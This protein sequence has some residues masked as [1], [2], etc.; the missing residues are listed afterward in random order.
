MQRQ[1]DRSLVLETVEVPI[2]AIAGTA[3]EEDYL[4]ELELIIDGELKKMGAVGASE[5]ARRK[6]QRAAHV[7]AKRVRYIRLTTGHQGNSLWISS[8]DSKLD[9]KPSKYNPHGDWNGYVS[10]RHDETIWS[11]L[12]SLEHSDEGGVIY[13][14]KHWSKPAH[15][16]DVR[17]SPCE[18]LAKTGKHDWF[19]V[20]TGDDICHSCGLLV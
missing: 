7:K 6:K 18:A 11:A 4:P 16:I 17:P 5:L 13:V 9:R 3:L 1:S 8:P 15:V 14:A 19:Y 10:S 12:R 20:P 2:S